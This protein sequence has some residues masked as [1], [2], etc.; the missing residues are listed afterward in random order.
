M[1]INNLKNVIYYDELANILSKKCSNGYT[2]LHYAAFKGNLDI[3]NS[4]IETIN[5]DLLL[6]ELVREKNTKGLTVLHMA[7]KGDQPG[8]IVFFK[9]KFNMNIN[10]KDFVG[11]TPLHYAAYIGAES[12]ITL[13][14][15]YLDDVN[16]QDN[17]G[18]TPLHLAVISGIKN[19]I[20]M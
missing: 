5:N 9:E 14:L 13:L 6:H 1:I 2:I 7:A 19:S 15:A 3:I 4:F 11:S 8:M 18:F 10:E 12:C 20:N 16:M 17:L